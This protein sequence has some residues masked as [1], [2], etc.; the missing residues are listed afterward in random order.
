M[1]ELTI[2]LDTEKIE[3]AVREAW[4]REFRAPDGYRNGENCGAGW[5]EVVR[6]V[7]AHIETLDLGAAIATAARARIDDVVNEVVTIALREKAKQ[8]A[9]EMMRDGTLLQ[10]PGQA[11]ER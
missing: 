7:K 6:Q 5:Q 10:Q 9:K 8:R 4:Q 11:D 1:I 2:K 3:S